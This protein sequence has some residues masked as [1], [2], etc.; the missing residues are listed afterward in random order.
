MAKFRRG[1]L[2]LNTNQ[3]IR[4][5]NNLESTI[6]FDGVNLTINSPNLTVDSG[7]ISSDSTSLT[8]GTV[9]LTDEGGVFNISSDVQTLSGSLTVGGVSGITVSGGDIVASHGRI[10]VGIDDSQQGQLLVYNGGEIYIYS[11]SGYDG[12]VDYLFIGASNSS[13]EFR[14]G[15]NTDPD[16]FRYNV[17]TDDWQFTGISPQLLL[18]TEGTGNSEGHIVLYGDDSN[19]GGTIDF[20]NP[21]GYSGTVDY[22]TIKAFNEN[23]EFGPNT[24]PNSLRYNTSTDDWQFTGVGPQL[25]LG[26]E[27]GANAWGQMILYGDDSNNGGTITIEN[28][29]SYSGTVDYFEIK[30]DS[31][32]L[33]IGPNTNLD[34]LKYNFSTDDWQFTGVA[35]QLLVGTEGGS[36]TQG[37][38]VLYGD[39]SNN[40]GTIDIE[41]AP[42]Y[43]G[44]IDFYRIKSSN[45]DLQIGPNTDAD[46]L[47]YSESASAWQFTTAN[48]VEFRGSGGINVGYEGSNSQGRIDIHGRTVDGGGLLYIHTAD[49]ADDTITSYILQATQ[50]DFEI[51]PSND[52][53][54]L[55]YTASTTTWDFTGGL[56]NIGADDSVNGLLNIYGDGGAGPTGGEIRLYN[57]SGY[58]GTYDYF[59][60]RVGQNSQDYL[61]IGPNTDPDSLQYDGSGH[62]IFTG[63]YLDVGNNDT[64]IA[65]FLNIYGGQSGNGTLTIYFP[66][67]YDDTFNSFSFVAS[68]TDTFE[69]GPNT[70]PD[71]LTYTSGGTWELRATATHITSGSFHVGVDDS[72]GGGIYVYG[73]SSKTGGKAQFFTAADKDDTISYYVTQVVSNTD[74]FAIG[75][76]HDFDALLYN[77]TTDQWVFSSSGGVE[78]N[79]LTVNS[80]KVSGKATTFVYGD[81]S[82]T[83]GDVALVDSTSVATISMTEA[84]DAVITVK[85]IGNADVVVQGLTGLIDGVASKTLSTRWESITAICDG[86]DWFIIG[87]V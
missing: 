51:G 6:E 55:K 22:F 66:A 73:S 30:A 49:N 70:D 3:Q 18:G 26:T 41:N 47:I 17:T 5:G 84:A 48:A 34:S 82:V 4:L 75:P 2:D 7:G 68:S 52:E 9:V 29:P 78:I 40:G 61:E 37:H 60:I 36:N 24:D 71:A 33:H 27:G 58:D 83:D 64:G 14:I 12:T 53:D 25:L 43:S 32:N 62:W 42:G 21:P 10:D 56:V 63:G 20:E 19:N 31:G 38:I 1:N 69:I 11:D 81:A 76:D 59:S 85:R 87:Q 65:G 50:D 13:E 39:D 45:S 54:S 72:V 35:P 86:T 15:P 8:I 79:S 77:G 28:S 67:D 57:P 16:S 23:W 44:T 80:K 74:N 46:A